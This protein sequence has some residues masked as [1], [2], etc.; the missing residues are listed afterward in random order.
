MLRHIYK[1][2]MIQ[3]LRYTGYSKKKAKQ[4]YDRFEAVM[5]AQKPV[6]QSSE[7]FKTS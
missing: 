7:V 6:F 2:Q 5:I 3:F 1:N 4:I